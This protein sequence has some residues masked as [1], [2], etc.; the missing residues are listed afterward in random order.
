MNQ[1]LSVYHVPPAPP[2]LAAMVTAPPATATLWP[3]PKPPLWKPL[4]LLSPIKLHTPVTHRLG[5][6]MVIWFQFKAV[7]AAK[8]TEYKCILPFNI[9]DRLEKGH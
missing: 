6:N 8:N 4:H 2:P 3:C 7:F 5:S 1:S 9:S